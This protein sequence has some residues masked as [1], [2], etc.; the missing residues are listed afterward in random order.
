MYE[1]FDRVTGEV[2]ATTKTKAGAR[3]V[4]DRRDRAYGCYRY[5][6]RE[7]GTNRTILH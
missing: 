2:V 1:I 5:A 4:A 7:A 6:I 3:R